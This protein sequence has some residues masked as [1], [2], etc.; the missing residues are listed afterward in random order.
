MLHYLVCIVCV[1]WGGLEK[2][3]ALDVFDVLRTDEDALESNFQYRLDIQ[4]EW[5]LTILSRTADQ[6]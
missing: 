6:P 5:I 3:T 2:D 4:G 1:E